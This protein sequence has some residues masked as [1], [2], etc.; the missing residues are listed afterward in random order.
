M[1]QYVFLTELPNRIRATITM[2][3]TRHRIN[4]YSTSAWP[5][6]LS[7]QPSSIR[8]R[9]ARRV[10]IGLFRSHRRGHELD[11]YNAGV[12]AFQHRPDRVGKLAGA[13]ALDEV[14][15]DRQVFL[16]IGGPFPAG[17]VRGARKKG[18]ELAQGQLFRHLDT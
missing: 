8:I 2:T 14:G 12:S 16:G 11:A 15:D 7:C 10:I 1:L 6:S 3:T 5:F 4:E 13:G 17:I 18:E 9:A